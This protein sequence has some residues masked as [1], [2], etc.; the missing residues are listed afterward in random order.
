VTAALAAGSTD[1]VTAVVVR[2]L[3]RSTGDDA[4]R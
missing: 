4:A 1:N 2:H 3:A